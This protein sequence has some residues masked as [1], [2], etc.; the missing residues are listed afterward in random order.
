MDMVGGWNGGNGRKEAPPREIA[1][2]GSPRRGADAD[3][4]GGAQN[5]QALRVMF[6]SFHIH[7]AAATAPGVAILATVGCR[8]GRARRRWPGKLAAALTPAARLNQDSSRSPTTL[9]AVSAQPAASQSPPRQRKIKYAAVTHP[10]CI[11]LA[12]ASMP[13]AT[14]SSFAGADGRASLCCQRRG[15]QIGG[16]VGNPHQ[17]HHRQQGRALFRAGPPGQQGKPGRHQQQPAQHGGLV[18]VHQL[19]APPQPQR[20]T[21]SHISSD[22]TC[23]PAPGIWPVLATAASSGAESPDSRFAPGR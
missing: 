18:A 4:A 14:P 10:Q 22:S 6:S 15:R 11:N 17:R 13:P 20:A 5:S 9:T 16:G 1:G 2:G 3:G 8:C 7:W 12:M 23:M 19:P 21:T